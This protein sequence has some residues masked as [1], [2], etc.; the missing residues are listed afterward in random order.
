MI[1]RVDR[2]L[3]DEYID[4]YIDQMYYTC[5]TPPNFIDDDAVVVV[6]NDKDEED[7]DA[8]EEPLLAL[9]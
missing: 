1:G 5:P 7:A 8:E 9:G 6:E 2:I 4:V 3:Y